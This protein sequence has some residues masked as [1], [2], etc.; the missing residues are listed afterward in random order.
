VRVSG[1]H[2]HPRKDLD[3]VPNSAC[4]AK[5]REIETGYGK[6]AAH[7]Y[8]NKSEGVRVRKSSM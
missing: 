4:R 1:E 8:E 7:G 5:P 6:P 2:S 3:R